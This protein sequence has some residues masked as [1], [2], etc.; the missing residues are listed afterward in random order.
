MKRAVFLVA[1]ISSMVCAQ[2]A[3]DPGA[4]VQGGTV[5]VALQDLRPAPE[6]ES[7]T[8]SKVVTNPAYGISRFGKDANPAGRVSVLRDK[9]SERLSSKF[10][11]SINLN[12]Y[13]F[14]MYSNNSAML[15]KIAVG[16]V[17][18]G[19][20]SAVATTAGEAIGANVAPTGQDISPLSSAAAFEASI[21]DEYLRGYYSAE[22]NPE[23]KWIYIV[24]LDAEINGKRN[25]VRFSQ[26]VLKSN[27]PLR[28]YIG[29]VVDGAVEKFV[30]LYM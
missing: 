1:L 30:S 2:Q 21:K 25:L 11:A 17:F 28:D 12:V 26:P 5:A 22:E 9:V 8:F 27:V 29:G 16:S 4:K 18:G 20:G 14:V 24:Y 10:S 19:L 6:K 15:R 3:A 7:V 13:H 23:N